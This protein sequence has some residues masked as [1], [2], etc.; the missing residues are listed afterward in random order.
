MLN[1]DGKQP[2][3]WG[4][5]TR[6]TQG[7]PIVVERVRLAEAG[8][9]IE[10]SFELPQLARLDAAATSLPAPTSKALIV[11]TGLYQTWRD[12]GEIGALV[13]TTYGWLLIAKS[14]AEGM[15]Q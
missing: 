6:L 8:I 13:T 7:Q 9:A 15:P 3:D 2:S 12:V 10:G 4:E 5:L 1:K 14:S 11:A